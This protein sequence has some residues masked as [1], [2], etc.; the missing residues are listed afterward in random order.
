MSLAPKAHLCGMQPLKLVNNAQLQLL[1][2]TR[3]QDYAKLA[4]S[5]SL[6]GILQNNNASTANFPLHFGM[7]QRKSAKA[8]TK[9]TLI[10][11]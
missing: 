8:A 11:M 9:Q 1:S 10:G 6:F 7:S 2:G 3:L 4:L 5:H